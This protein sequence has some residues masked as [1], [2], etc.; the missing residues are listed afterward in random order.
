MLFVA[1]EA[2]EFSGLLKFCRSVKKLDWPL[3]WVCSAELKGRKVVLAANGAGP[4]LAAQ[5]KG[6]GNGEASRREAQRPDAATLLTGCARVACYSEFI[7]SVNG[8][9]TIYGLV[10]KRRNSL[11]TAP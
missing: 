7:R 11:K 8:L 2:R 3:D 1:A 9:A 5:H 6:Q 10:T 4:K